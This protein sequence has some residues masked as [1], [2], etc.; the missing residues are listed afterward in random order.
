MTSGYPQPQN[1]GSIN[2]E[3]ADKVTPSRNLP[4][5]TPASH[6]SEHLPDEVSI[7]IFLL[8]LVP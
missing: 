4:D 7:N 2:M 6:N 1:D 8:T 5:Q 3:Q